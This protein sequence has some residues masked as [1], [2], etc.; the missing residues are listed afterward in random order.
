M[1]KNTNPKQT[2]ISKIETTNDVIASRGG[3]TFFSTLFREYSCLP[4]DRA[5]AWNNKRFEKRT[6]YAGIF[7]S[8]NVLFN[9]WQQYINQLF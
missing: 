2:K 4:F 8:T 7:D 1:N 9:G 6:W 5:S 3:L